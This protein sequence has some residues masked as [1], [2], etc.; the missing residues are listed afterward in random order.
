M[1]DCNFEL[2]DKPMSSFKLGASSFPEFSSLNGYLNRSMSE[3][4]PDQGLI[5]KGMY[6]I[7]ES[8]GFSRFAR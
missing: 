8:A 7:F 1:I 2:N 5:P 3:C 6:C 4:V